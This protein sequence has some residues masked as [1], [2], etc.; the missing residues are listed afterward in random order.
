MIHGKAFAI[1]LAA[2]VILTLAVSASAHGD[3]WPDSPPPQS[4]AAPQ[5]TVDSQART[6]R[7]RTLAL[8]LRGATG[9][10]REAARGFESLPLRCDPG[11]GALRRTPGV[12]RA[13]ASRKNSIP[14]RG[15]ASA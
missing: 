9:G 6:T 13:Q 15:A 4:V 12:D 1:T 14:Y 2:G 5:T 10:R 8:N 3:Q 7:S 11:P